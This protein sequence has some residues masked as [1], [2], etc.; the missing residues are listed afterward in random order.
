MKFMWF[1][2]LDSLIHWSYRGMIH[3]QHDIR[4][5]VWCAISQAWCKRAGPRA[6]APSGSN[7]LLSVSKSMRYVNGCA[8]R[9]QPATY[10]HP[11]ASHSRSASRSMSQKCFRPHCHGSSKFLTMKDA[12]KTRARLCIHPV[13]HSCRIAASTM[14]YPVM[15]CRQALKRTGQCV[16][17]TARTCSSRDRS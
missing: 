11:R 2:G 6:S 9:K 7:R 14:G 4:Q 5:G 10:C 12:V 15:P 8:S 16:H 17:G 13:T 1:M 3:L